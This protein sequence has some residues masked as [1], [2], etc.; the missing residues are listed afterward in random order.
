MIRKCQKYQLELNSAAV[1]QTLGSGVQF[2]RN[3]WMKKSTTGK[4]GGDLPELEN[5]TLVLVNKL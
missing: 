1:A 5:K 4:G 3:I 2:L